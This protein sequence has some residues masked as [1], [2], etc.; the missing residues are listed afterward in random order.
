[1]KIIYER[2]EINICTANKKKNGKKCVTKLEE[3]TRRRKLNIAL[4]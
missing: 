4:M 2:S 3:Q 1:M